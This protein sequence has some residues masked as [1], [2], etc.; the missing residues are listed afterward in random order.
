MHIL[1]CIAFC[2][3]HLLAVSQVNKEGVPLITNYYPK[4]YNAHNENWMSGANRYG[5]LYFAN[6]SG[7]VLEYDGKSWN[8]LPTKKRTVVYSLA[9]DSN[10]VIYV[11]AQGD[12]GYYIPDKTGKLV[13][14]SLTDSI[15]E[16]SISKQTFWKTYVDRNQCVYFCSPS[17]IYIYKNNK[18]SSIQLPKNSW[19]SFCI[20]DEIY[21]SNSESG[22][23]KYNGKTFE[24][25]KGFEKFIGS[26]IQIIDEISS[27]EWIVF[28]GVK[29]YKYDLIEKKC[30]EINDK[31]EIWD[32]LINNYAYHTIGLQKQH[33]IWSTISGGV[34]V[35]SNKWGKHFII[36]DSLGL[37]SSQASS[38]NYLP[39]DGT[40]WITTLNG[41]SKIE[42]E[43]PI[44]LFGANQSLKGNVYNIKKFKDKLYVA[45]SNG[46]YVLEK[47]RINSFFKKVSFFKDNIVNYMEVIQ[48]QQGERLLI[49][50]Q[51][52]L[53]EYD[54]TTFH[55]MIKQEIIAEYILQSKYKK[56]IFIGAQNG[57][58]EISEKNTIR[59]RTNEYV[60]SIVED[61]NENIWFSTLSNGV[62]CLTP[63]GNLLH[64]NKE[65]GLPVLNDVY[66]FI[67]KS[68]V[69]L[70]TSKGLYY[71]DKNK[72]IKKC[73][74]FGKWLNES[75]K[76]IISCYKGFNN[77]LWLNISNRLYLLIP[78]YDE[79]D[80]D[81]ITFKRIPESTI[82]HVYSEPNGITWIGTNEGLFSFDPKWSYPKQPF[83]CLIRNVRLGFN[84]SV[85]FYGTYSHPIKKISFNQD[86]Q[87]N[88][89][90]LDYKFNAL[91]FTYAAP[92][93]Q[94][95][96]KTEYSYMLEGFDDH[97]S[98]WTKEN[99]AILPIFP[100][101][102]IY[103]R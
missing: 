98:S 21:V 41:I 56:S 19:L 23:L 28:N 3:L 24:S 48:N 49:S 44:K 84:D 85:I 27:K 74:H 72:Q 70:C 10:G 82:Y 95:E 1:I 103:L 5:L 18:L 4:Q 100:K 6:T 35:T 75:E 2:V 39:I 43:N 51:N 66:L 99:K 79:F 58:Y 20:N 101:V 69:L 57:L 63:N 14:V 46:L 80:V 54:G 89:Y 50:S 22:L 61:S 8:Q 62:Y 88:K 26:D 45:T 55:R 90:V 29:F 78:H 93:Y 17:N 9:C 60:I 15:D 40:I 42:Y 25:V 47:N 11:G 30:T 92:F 34:V 86:L 12:F 33:R 91:T 81:S 16:A 53:F 65:K 97:W 71:I 76:N 94:E 87:F 67:W 68:D 73:D 38:V 83:H 32:Y 77:Q 52:A 102:N 64:Y 13:Y 59:K 36:N 31:S 7:L 96:H 37:A